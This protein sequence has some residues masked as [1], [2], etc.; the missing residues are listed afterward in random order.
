MKGL[1]EMHQ[2][3]IHFHRG[4]S[5]LLKPAR[6]MPF[7]AAIPSFSTGSQLILSQETVRQKVLGE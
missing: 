2:K 4:L 6:N 3:H 1:K 7:T 5:H